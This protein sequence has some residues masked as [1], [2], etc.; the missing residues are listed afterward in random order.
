M[1]AYSLEEV[2]TAQIVWMLLVLAGTLLLGLFSVT[3]FFILSFIGLLAVTQL[4]HPRGDPPKWWRWVH[5][6][7][8]ACFVGFAYVVYL[9]VIAVI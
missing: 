3:V 6:L 2:A 1:Y 5:P 4:Y 7:I 8:G 9:Q